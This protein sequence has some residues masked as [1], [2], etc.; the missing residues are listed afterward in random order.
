VTFKW[1]LSEPIRKH[2]NASHPITI[3]LFALSITRTTRSS[4]GFGSDF[5]CNRIKAKRATVKGKR[6][7]GPELSPGGTHEDDDDSEDDE[8]TR[9]PWLHAVTVLN[10]FTSYLCD[11]QTR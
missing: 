3:F 2:E 10:S 11:H 6:Q 1:F 7:S 9:F 8:T 4:V 5:E